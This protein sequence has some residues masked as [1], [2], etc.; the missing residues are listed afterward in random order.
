MLK[1][2]VLF[3]E[4][5]HIMRWGWEDYQ[6]GSQYEDFLSKDVEHLGSLLD[7]MARFRDIPKKVLID[8]VIELKGSCQ[9]HRHEETDR[10]REGKLMGDKDMFNQ[11]CWGGY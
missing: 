10:C 4:C 11:D 3:H 9:F 2:L 7:G 5:V 6:S 1:E 8:P